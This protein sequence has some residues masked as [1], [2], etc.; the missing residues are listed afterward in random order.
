MVGSCRTATG[1][2][3]QWWEKV[4]GGQLSNSNRNCRSVVGD[5]SVVGSCRTATGSVLVLDYVCRK[6]EV[7]D[8][9]Y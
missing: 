9:V 4:S 7:L 2:V 8:Y 6:G 1:S 3:G 5:R